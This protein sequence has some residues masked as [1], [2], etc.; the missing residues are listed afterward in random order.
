MQQLLLSILTI[1]LFSACQQDLNLAVDFTPKSLKEVQGGEADYT[2]TQYPVVLVHGLYGFKDIFG[3]NYF[4]LVPEALELGGAK[5]YIVSVSGLESSTARGEQLLTQIHDIL[6]ISGAEKVNLIGHSHGGPTSRY[7]ASVEP[8]IIASVAT[9]HGVNDGGSGTADAISE[10]LHKP[11]TGMPLQAMFNALAALIDFVAR[12]F[13]HQ[14]ALASFDSLSHEGMTEF[15]VSHPQALPHSTCGDGDHEVNGVKYYSWG[16]NKIKTNK[17]DPLDW[18]MSISATKIDG[19]SDGM[20]AQCD[21]NLGMVIRND[22]QHNH[23]DAMNWT[24]GLR[25]SGS[26]N[27]L[28]IYRTH[29]NRLKIAGL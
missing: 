18:L 3:M 9:S 15:N 2:E 29:V 28:V 12:D 23:L 6:A 11:L 21:Q 22:Y 17:L 13:H 16:G 5:V 4:H 8:G 26:V 27:P 7:V 25:K 14:S 24:I 19:P 10:A 20:V 1:I